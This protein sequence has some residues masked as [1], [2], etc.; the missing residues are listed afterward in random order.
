MFANAM[1]DR[2]TQPVREAKPSRRTFLK[3]TGGAGAGLV[4]GMALPRLGASGAAAAAEFEPNPFVRVAPDDRCT[5]IP[6]SMSRA[7]TAS[8]CPSLARSFITTTMAYS[9]T[10]ESGRS[11]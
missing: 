9:P 8:I 6:S 2:L 7:I 4:I 3:I 1:I 5:S 10:P 11:P